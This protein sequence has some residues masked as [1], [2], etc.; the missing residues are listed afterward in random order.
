V[1]T[2][3][4]KPKGGCGDRKGRQLTV[5][6]KYATRA[7][8]LALGRRAI[9]ARGLVGWLGPVRGCGDPDDAVHPP[10]RVIA[11]ELLVRARAHGVILQ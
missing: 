2:P 6:L 5:R 4:A 8:S 7:D 9:P 10:K 11:L 3:A 1:D